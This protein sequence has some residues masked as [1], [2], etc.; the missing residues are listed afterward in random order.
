VDIAMA[1]DHLNEQGDAMVDL[2]IVN[3]AAGR[4]DDEAAALIAAVE[5]YEAKGN[6]VRARDASRRL[7]CHRGAAASMI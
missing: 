5:I 2:A 4:P 7:A 6:V 3:E 1:T